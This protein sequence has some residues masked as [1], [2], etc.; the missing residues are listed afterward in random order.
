MKT[1]KTATIP[2]IRSAPLT[3]RYQIDLDSKTTIELDSVI[4][5]YNEYQ[6]V[7]LNSKLI[8]NSEQHKY[9]VKANLK[10]NSTDYN[11]NNETIKVFYKIKGKS[12]SIKIE[13]FLLKEER[14]R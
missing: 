14:K 4:L 2:G 3:I 1:V 5:K 6:R 7:K 10:I 9:Q 13:N 8:K 12:K 11:F